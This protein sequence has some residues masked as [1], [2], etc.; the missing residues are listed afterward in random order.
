[1]IPNIQLSPFGLTMLSNLEGT[2]LR[3]YKD[4]AGIDTVCTG[5]VVRPGDGIWIN[6]GITV[7]VCRAVLADDVGWCLDAI[8]K[9][10]QVPLAQSMI[11]ALVCLIFNIGP[12]QKGFAGSTVLRELNAGNYRAAGDAFLLWSIVTVDGVRK[13]LLTKRRQA[14]RA[15]FLTDIPELP[16]PGL[17]DEWLAVRDQANVEL[18]EHEQDELMA[19]V[20]ITTD[21]MIGENI[22]EERRLALE[23]RERA[24]QELITGHPVALP[25]SKKAMS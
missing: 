2:V 11:D 22:E 10:V 7:P 6:N 17:N 23:E 25:S 18:S 9:L 20:A 12:A 5:H 1:M 13:P 24:W 4:Q 15:V 8:V 16:P 19:L 14:E 21:R 3:V